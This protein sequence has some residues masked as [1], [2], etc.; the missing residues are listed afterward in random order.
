[1]RYLVRL[2]STV[3]TFRAMKAVS[4]GPEPMASGTYFSRESR[5]WTCWSAD[6]RSSRRRALGRIEDRR[7]RSGK[8]SLN[9]FRKSVCLSMIMA[10][11]RPRYDKRRRSCSM[12][13]SVMSTPRR[14]ELRF[15]GRPWSGPGSSSKWATFL[16][17]L[18]VI[19]AVLS[20][21]LSK[22]PGSSGPRSG[23]SFGLLPIS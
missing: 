8:S 11:R 10:R 22:R 3:S 2:L 1:M 7:E 23:S 6:H 13:S 5:Q 20:T 4:P 21:Y 17:A 15:Q 19:A 18:C 12:S 9:R 14:V 16:E